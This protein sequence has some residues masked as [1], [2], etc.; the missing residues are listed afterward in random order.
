M[1]RGHEMIFREAIYQT[2][3]IASLFTRSKCPRKCVVGGEENC[4]RDDK[5][6]VAQ[7][8]IHFCFSNYAV[9]IREGVATLFPGGRSGLGNSLEMVRFNG[10]E[11]A[12]CVQSYYQNNNSYKTIQRLFRAHFRLHDIRQCPSANVIKQWVRKFEATGNTT[13]RRH[14]GRRR[15]IRSEDN[16]ERVRQ[17]VAA[18]PR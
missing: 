3:S 15:S 4:E 5:Y 7:K 18:D 12:F 2:D 11:H 16:I 9:N 14:V 13:N 6:W 1:C 8:G 17:S 10:A